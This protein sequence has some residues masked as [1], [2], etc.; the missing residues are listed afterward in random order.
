MLVLVWAWATPVGAQAQD[1]TLKQAAAITLASAQN[2]APLV[3]VTIAGKTYRFLFDLSASFTLIDARLVRVLALPVESMPARLKIE[4]EGVRATGLAVLPDLQVGR[5]PY[6][7]VKAAEIDRRFPSGADGVIG[8][9][10]LANFDLDLDLKAGKLNLFSPDHCPGKVVYWASNY[11]VVP[12]RMDEAGHPYFTATLDE[13]RVTVSFDAGDSGG[14]MGMAD[15]NDLFGIVPD[16]RQL[17]PLSS[18]E[19]GQKLYRYPFKELSLGGVK[20]YHPAI[21][22]FPQ[23]P[24]EQCRAV[25]KD[26]ADLPPASLVF[27]S[28]R[29]CYGTTALYLGRSELAQLHVY[30]A[31]GEKKLYVTA[32]S[33]A[34]ATPTAEG[35]A[36]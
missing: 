7:T 15:A 26:V 6:G 34:G 19:D 5:I 13:R 25:P 2:G 9:D 1:C 10:L 35:S 22:L 24:T 30:F 4:F 28:W 18:S 3:P 20:I 12:F 32:A 27:G 14:A 17:V 23:K 8:L 11:A 31:F 21:S 33:G 29:A 16:D 36:P